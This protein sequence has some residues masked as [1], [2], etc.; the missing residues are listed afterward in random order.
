MTKQPILIYKNDIFLGEVPGLE[1]ASHATGIPISTISRKIIDGSHSKD[2]FSF[3]RTTEAVDITKAVF[4]VSKNND[5][6]DAYGISGVCNIVRASAEYVQRCIV[7]GTACKG[8]TIWRKRNVKIIAQSAVLE[9]FDGIEALKKIERVA[10]ICYASQDKITE[11]SYLVFVKKLIESGHESVIE[12][13]HVTAYAVVDRGIAQEL[14]RHRIGS[15]TH[16]S[17]RYVKYD[18]L[19]IITDSSESLYLFEFA[20][21]EYK[22]LLDSGVTAEIARDVLPLSTASHIVMTY[23]LRQWRNIFRQRYLG[24]TGT[25]HPRMVSLMESLLKQFKESIPVI[26]DDIPL[27]DR[28]VA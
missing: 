26:F 28:K 24:E 11:D 22:R 10:R 17:T 13:V 16:E 6:F 8:Y 27:V 4:V 2:G 20:E 7:N 25:P 5:F 18:E 3:D 9:K 12:H 23:N 14:T 1:A 21:K 15:Y 19:S